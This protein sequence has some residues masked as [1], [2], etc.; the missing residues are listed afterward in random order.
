MRTTPRRALRPWLPRRRMSPREYGASSITILEGLEAVRKRPGMYIGSTGERGLHHL[1]WEVVDN[2]VD[3]AM[4]GYATEVDVR[5]LDDGGVEVTDDGRGIPVAMHA[6][7]HP[8]R[9]R[10]H[11]PAPCRRQVR[12]REQRLH[13]QS[14]ACTASASRWSTRCRTRLEVDISRDGYEW[15]QYYDQSVPGTLKQG[16]KTQEDRHHDQVL[17]R[18]RHLRDHRL[19]LRDGRAAAAGDGVPQQGI[20]HQPDRRAGHAG[21]GRRRRRQRHGRGAEVRRGEGRRSHRTAQGQA[22]HLPLP[23]R[24]GRLRQAHQPHQEPDPPEHRRLRR[25]GPRPRGRD[26][27]AVERRLF[28]VGAHL[29][30]HHQHARGRHPRRRL[31]QLR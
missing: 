15:S 27:D 14:A 6:T 21:R 3:E 5:I 8:H 30:Q 29:R 19:R 10:R 13:G 22:P 7:G 17:G 16:E 2:S 9:R 26:R 18:S 11:D 12:W 28:G 24:P 4:A 31:P 20:D 23:R 25:Q 1:I